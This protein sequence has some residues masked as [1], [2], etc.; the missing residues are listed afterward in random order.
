V[1]RLLCPEDEK[2]FLALEEVIALIR[3]AGGIPCYPVLLDDPKGNFTAFEA[4]YPIM[5]ESLKQ[6]GI[7]MIELIP[8]RND[9]NILRDFVRFFHRAGFVITF[10]SE[11]NTPALEPLTITCRGNADPGD[12]LKKISYRGAAIIAAHQYLTSRNQ[13]GFPADALPSAE[14]L[15]EMARLGERVITNFIHR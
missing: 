5:A 2:A 3:D 15:D 4:D 8:G 7:Y 6:S 1:V 9:A 10:G 14:V 11:H 13:P 12:E